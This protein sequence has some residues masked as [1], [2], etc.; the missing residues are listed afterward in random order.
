MTW[1]S[2]TDPENP[3]NWPRSR[4]WTAT[5]L[6]SCFTFISPVSSTML[7][8]ALPMLATDLKTGSEIETYFLMSIFLLAYAIGPFVIAPLSEMHGRVTVLQSANMVFLLFNTIAGWSKNKEMM[9]AM[10]FLSGI[11]GS[12]P[13]AV[14]LSFLPFL[15]A[16]PVDQSARRRGSQ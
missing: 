5:F 6:V 11:G 15:S 10:R 3:R 9:L 16:T 1:D 4:K 2:E 8:P 12:A 13:Q 7:A 14:R